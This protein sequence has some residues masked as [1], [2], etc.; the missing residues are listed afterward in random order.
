MSVFEDEE[1]VIVVDP[2]VVA[3]PSV[4]VDIELL[5]PEAVDG[6][7]GSVRE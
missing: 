5:A 7:A 6:A 1:G 2:R 3:A 4:T